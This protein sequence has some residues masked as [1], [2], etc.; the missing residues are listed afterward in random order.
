MKLT[1]YVLPA[2]SLAGAWI[3]LAPARPSLAFSKLGD[4]LGVDQRDV[5]LFNNFEDATANDNVTPASQFPGWLMAELAIWKS[6]VEWGSG[7]HG[8]GTGDPLAGNVLGSGGA[9]FDA[10]WSG[11][12]SNVG[13][14]NQNI[15]SGIHDCGGAGTLAFTE[16]PISDGWRIRFCDEW[17]WD[18]GPGLVGGR[19]DIQSVMTHEYGHAIG[20]GHSTVSNATMFPSTSVGSTSPRSI[21]ADDTA[22]VQCV[23]GAASPLKPVIVATVA[24]AG[25]GTLT[26]FGT[27]FHVT[28]N[29]VW[30]TNATVTSPSLDPIVRV[31][32]VPSDTAE[33]TVVVP[34]NA[35]PGDVIVKLPGLSASTISNAFPTD[36][37]GTFGTP[38][39][40]RPRLVSVTP[41]AIEAL[42]PGTAQTV[43]LA[44]SHLDLV[45]DVQLDE[46]SIDPARYTIVDASTLTLD[47]PQASALGSHTLSVF[48]AT[49]GDTLLVEIVAPA[50]A[51]LEVGTG[52]AANPVDKDDGV[53][54]IVSGAVGEL[55]VVRAAPGA[56]PQLDRFLNLAYHRPATVLVNGVGLTIP[57]QGW[58]A[59]HLPLLPDPAVVGSAW[60][61][62]SFVLGGPRPFPTSN[63][64]TI[65]LL[66]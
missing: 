26:I 31:L 2:L 40:P 46:D 29:E 7:P 50:T 20:L 42:I 62:Q 51:E 49:N 63:L 10:M 35:G 27:G 24:D 64:Q 56:A 8:D 54:L 28:N 9:N 33:L 44:G 5:R 21:A 6:I 1:P 22:G 66:P 12:A 59:H 60:T 19:V 15:V 52:D 4:E 25:A 58:A 47:M 43:T 16:T 13:T 39:A 14:A 53:D 3:L 36:L 23:Y 41:S 48:D 55:H 18:D 32:G 37:V 38:P 11:N 61:F 30:F 34:A 57:A 17:N 45:L 65:T